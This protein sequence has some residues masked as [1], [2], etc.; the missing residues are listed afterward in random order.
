MP[1]YL[2]GM[3][4]SGTIRQTVPAED[5]RRVRQP[6]YFE[7]FRCIG[8]DCEDTC[9][10]GWGIPVDQRTYEKYQSLTSHRIA[11]KP[12]TTLVEINPAGSSTG[13]YAK[14]RL[15]GGSCPALHEGMCGIQESLGEAYLPDLCSKYPRV[16][17]MTGGAVERSLHLSC[18]EAARLVLN[19]PEAMVFHERLEEH[20]P[21]RSRSLSAITDDPDGQMYQVRARVIELIQERSVRLWKRIVVLGFAVDRLAGVD[22]AQA[23][24]VLEDCIERL[25]NGAFDGIFRVLKADPRFQLETVLELVVARIG[26]D[27]TA[28]RF[29]EC[30]KEFMLGLAWAPEC[31]LEELT[32]RYSFASQRF[33]RPF[34]RLHEHVLENYLVN[35]IFRTVFPYRSRLPEQKFAI[36]SSRKSMRHSLVLLATHYAII[37]AMLIGMAGLHRESLSTEHA[38]KLVQSYSKAF[39]HSTA[40]ET[41]A[42]EYLEKNVADPAGKVAEL[43]MD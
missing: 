10:A 13:D 33:F 42:I 8:A 9:C 22:M 7:G 20:V 21:H 23:S 40:F 16:L 38:V 32:A 26:T 28:P 17:N 18:P 14:L 35:Y 30:Y 19:D 4:G 36:D 11:D 34:V 41:E 15:E 2:S 24:V 29:L 25:R 37:R 3:A 27:Y 6:K 43:V 5:V 39:L 1:I 31:S 12:L